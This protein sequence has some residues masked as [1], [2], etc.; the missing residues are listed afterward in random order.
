MDEAFINSLY[1]QFLAGHR[2]DIRMMAVDQS[3]GGSQITVVK[4]TFRY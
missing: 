1:K 2:D 3:I 4:P